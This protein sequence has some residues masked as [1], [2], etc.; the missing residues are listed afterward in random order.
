MQWTDVSSGLFQSDTC[1]LCNS[2]QGS[3]IGSYTVCTS[4]LYNFI[5]SDFAFSDHKLLNFSFSFPIITYNHLQKK[6]K[7]SPIVKSVLWVHLLSLSIRASTLSD[8]LSCNCPSEICCIYNNAIS[9]I[10]EKHA[11]VKTRLFPSSH[12]SPWFTPDLRAMKAKGCRLE[13]LYWKSG[14]TLIC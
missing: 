3:Y 6:K 1:N 4:G 9:K 11:P 5:G 8:C 13:R 7:N 14:V 12:V 10:L 2:L